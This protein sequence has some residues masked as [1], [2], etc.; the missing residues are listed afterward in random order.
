MKLKVSDLEA[1]VAYLKKERV[2]EVDLL[3]GQ[4]SAGCGVYAD[5]EFEDADGANCTVR[6]YLSELGT[7]R[8][9]IKDMVHGKKEKKNGNV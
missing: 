6:C 9:L 8:R 5:F 4:G 2:T 3:A 1:T 7:Q